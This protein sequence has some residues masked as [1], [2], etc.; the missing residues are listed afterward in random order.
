MV[1]EGEVSTAV[2][3]AGYKAGNGTE[4]SYLNS[5]NGHLKPLLLKIRDFYG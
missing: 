2:P 3:P 5:R 1:G 4:F